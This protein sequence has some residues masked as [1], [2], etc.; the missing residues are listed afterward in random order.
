[1]VRWRKLF[2]LM[3]IVPVVVAV[4]I[5][6]ASAGEVFKIGVM[7]PMTGPA[8]KIGEEFKGS[9]KMAFDEIDWT[10]GD[11]KLEITWIDSQSDPAKA[12]NAY[13]EAVERAGIEAAFTNWH[14]S[15]A[16]AAMEVAAKYQI[17]HFWAFGAASTVNEKWVSD[18]E[19]YGYWT[20]KAW[21][22][23]AKLIVGYR[24]VLEEAIKTGHW[25]PPQKLFPTH[26]FILQGNAIFL[27]YTPFIKHPYDLFLPRQGSFIFT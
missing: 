23:P 4:G 17:P 5:S 25:K 20:G 8:A 27:H 3:L 10:I 14:S 24:D 7:G 1:M 2:L 21:P 18:P 22:Y 6:T 12:T 9:V 13:S 15:V 19:K 16:V 11:Y 26:L